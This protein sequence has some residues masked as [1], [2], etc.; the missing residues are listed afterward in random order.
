MNVELGKSEVK[1]LVEA[2]READICGDVAAAFE[3]GAKAEFFHGTNFITVITI[4]R[5]TFWTDEG[6]LCDNTGNIL[7]LY[8]K[9]TVG[10]PL[11]GSLPSSGPSPHH[12]TNL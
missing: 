7:S 5:S 2:V 8:R 3:T 12:G 9:L 1:E 10:M 11:K 4:D 6:E